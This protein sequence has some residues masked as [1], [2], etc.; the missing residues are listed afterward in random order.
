MMSIVD[1][2]A[3]AA[4]AAAPSKRVVEL[5]DIT[6]NGW[7][8]FPAGKRRLKTEAVRNEDEVQVTLWV[9]RDAPHASLSRYDAMA[10]AVTVL[11]DEYP[12]TPPPLPGLVRSHTVDIPYVSGEL[13]HDAAFH[14]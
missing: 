2:L 5:R 8:A 1:R 9:W 12:A 11:A 14:F 4:Q 6:L 10:S 7:I 3:A 13:F